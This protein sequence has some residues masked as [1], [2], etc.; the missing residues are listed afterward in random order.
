MAE[1]ADVASY[2]RGMDLAAHGAHGYD[3]VVVKATEGTGYVNPYFAREFNTK[4][5]GFADWWRWAGTLGLAR[6][7]YHFARP[8]QWGGAA[9]A[10]WFHRALRRAG[11]LGP[12]DW[13][14]LDTEESGQERRA[15]LHAAEFCERMVELGYRYGWVYAGTYYLG[16]AELTPDRLPEGWRNLW[17][18]NY[19]PVGD[20]RVPLPA[21]WPRELLV[22]RQYT[23]SASQPGIPGLSDANRVV[24][25][26]LD[27]RSVEE[28]PVTEQEM[29]RIA[30]K[31]T[32]LLMRQV[33]E[34][35]V[36][37]EA[38]PPTR[39]G[40]VG[41]LLRSTNNKAGWLQKAVGGQGG[42]SDR[43]GLVGAA[44]AAAR[45]EV[46]VV[47]GKVDALHT[48]AGTEPV[49][50]EL[51][52]MAPSPVEHMLA[53]LLDHLGVKYPPTE[54]QPAPEQE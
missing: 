22:A 43:V 21:G 46:A 9:E 23:S 34:D 11:G 45:Q 26:W 54:R 53:V 52:E 24:R 50:G 7:A 29:D 10:D 28:D 12:R 35:G 32:A 51:L 4:T 3:R 39:Q 19:N 33:R 15:A 25:E 16:L 49:V 1:F 41:A 27:G 2:Q 48:V 20:D 40:S 30:E 14:V 18:A 37:D 36:E 44:V 31:V 38:N 6:G 42:L 17:L 47:S 13:P 5:S 8:S